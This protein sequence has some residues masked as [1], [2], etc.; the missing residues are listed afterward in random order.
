[1]FDCFITNFVLSHCLWFYQFITNYKFCLKLWSIVL[2]ITFITTPQN[3]VN[4]PIPID[5]SQY[6]EDHDNEKD[7]VE[8]VV[9]KRKRQKTK[10]D[11]NDFEE[12]ELAGGVK[13]VVCKYGKEKFSTSG[14]GA[15]T[16]I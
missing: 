9:V 2:L 14:S 5:A 1:M 12:A 15:S 4:E 7:Q 8:D 3:K 11:W 6:G 13:K 10:S 16:S